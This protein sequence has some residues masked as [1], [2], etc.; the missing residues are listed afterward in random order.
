MAEKRSTR[1]FLALL[2]VLMILSL[3]V[4]LLSLNVL[5]EIA[6]A[7]QSGEGELAQLPFGYYYEDY[8]KDGETLEESSSESILDYYSCSGD[9][10]WHTFGPESDTKSEMVTD[11]G[12]NSQE[13]IDDGAGGAYCE[14]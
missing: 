4:D 2:V 8:L 6:E 1:K 3:V 7:K 9:E 10:V 5:Y 11:C 14:N 13:C 12:A